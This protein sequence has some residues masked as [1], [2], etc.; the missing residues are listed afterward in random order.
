MPLC[1]KGILSLAFV[2]RLFLTA[3]GYSSYTISFTHLKSY[4]MWS[5]DWHP[6]CSIMFRKLYFKS[7]IELTKI[8]LVF[9]Q[10]VF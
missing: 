6:S 3:L 4:N 1:Y 10:L 8:I 5:C 7:H 9:Q 2:G